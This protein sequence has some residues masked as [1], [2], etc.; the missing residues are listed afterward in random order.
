M[1]KGLLYSSIGL[2][3]MGGLG[4]WIMF[5]P[6]FEKGMYKNAGMEALSLLILL[7]GFLLLPGAL[8]KGGIPS[9]SLFWKVMVGITLTFLL[10]A[11]AAYLLLILV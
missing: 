1:D 10:A 4:L 9:P 3:V 11:L 2:M 5:F 7:M 6:P 8:F